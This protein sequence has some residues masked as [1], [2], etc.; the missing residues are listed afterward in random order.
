MIENGERSKF[1]THDALVCKSCNTVF[2]GK[3]S[4]NP[5]MQEASDMK[6]D[7]QKGRSFDELTPNEPERKDDE[8]V[9][10]ERKIGSESSARIRP[11]Y[12]ALED[13]Y[14]EDGTKVSAKP[15]SLKNPENEE[16]ET[17]ERKID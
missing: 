15:E 7:D 16:G 11:A 14:F 17:N 10:N 9:D 4:L 8:E 5:H 2:N 6:N 13:I 1:K 3:S 12:D